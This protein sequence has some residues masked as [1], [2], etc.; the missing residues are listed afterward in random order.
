MN[1][2]PSALSTALAHPPG[3]Q[4][5]A[6]AEPE[7]G[8]AGPASSVHEAR[9]MALRCESTI[10]VSL[11]AEDLK[12]EAFVNLQR[13]GGPSAPLPV[14]SFRLAEMDLAICDGAGLALYQLQLTPTTLGWKQHAISYPPAEELRALREHP[15]WARRARRLCLTSAQARACRVSVGVVAA[16]A[17]GAEEL[18]ALEDG[19]ESVYRLCEAAAARHQTLG[20]AAA[21]A[22]RRFLADVEK[23]RRPSHVPL[24]RL[25][26]A[27]AEELAFGHSVAA[28]CSRSGGFSDSGDESKAAN[29]LFRRLGLSGHRESSGQMRYARVAS[30]ATAELLCEVLDMAPEQVGL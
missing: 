1:N 10:S 12:G 20:K 27:L 7:G 15:H 3:E 30:Y 2:V 19:E 24:Y 29:R 4:P 26:G 18:G 11:G 6:A 9:E 14:A 5:T 22:G 28:L 17:R 8:G 13:T 21:K 16:E 25:Q 23:A